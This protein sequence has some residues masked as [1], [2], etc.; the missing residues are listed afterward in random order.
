M[1]NI[2]SKPTILNYVAKYPIATTALLSWHK[3]FSKATFKNFNELKAVYS[4]ASILANGRV[5]FNIKEIRI[6]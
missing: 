3:D 5:I 4:S 1:M 6:G 2:V